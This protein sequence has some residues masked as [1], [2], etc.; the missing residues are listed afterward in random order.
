LINHS[1]IIESIQF[2]KS[3]SKITTKKARQHVG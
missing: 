2:F 1:K 3:N